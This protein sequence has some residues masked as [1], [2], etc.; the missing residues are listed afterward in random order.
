MIY[1]VHTYLWVICGVPSLVLSVRLS[2][3]L[4]KTMDKGLPS[5]HFS[6]P[7]WLSVKR[8]PVRNWPTLLLTR[9]SHSPSSLCSIFFCG[10]KGKVKWPEDGSWAEGQGPLLAPLCR[11]WGQL[12]Q[13]HFLLWGMGWWPSQGVFQIPG[14]LRQNADFSVGFRQVFLLHPF[15]SL[16]VTIHEGI[17]ASSDKD[18]LFITLRLGHLGGSSLNVPMLPLI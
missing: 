18:L 11:V 5:G 3:S 16:C 15:L 1:P 14:G 7:A 9:A 17:F 8:V 6:R 12:T 13:A 10:E 4:V 2:E